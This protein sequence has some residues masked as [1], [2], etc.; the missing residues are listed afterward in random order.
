MR[1][2][3][4]PSYS[5]FQMV[6]APSA[7]LSGPAGDILLSLSEAPW[8][9]LSSEY[10]NPLA[11]IYGKPLKQWQIGFDEH[12]RCVLLFLD[13]TA[14]EGVG[15]WTLALDGK[16]LTQCPDV[17]P[18]MAA[19]AALIETLSAVF[20]ARNAPALTP[21]MFLEE[22]IVRKRWP[23]VLS[24]LMLRGE[25]MG[26]LKNTLFSMLETIEPVGFTPQHAQASAR[27]LQVR[28]LMVFH[29]LIDDGVIR[30]AAE[31]KRLC[32]IIRQIESQNESK[33]MAPVAGPWWLRLLKT[34][35]EE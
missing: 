15:E 10:D 31:Q 11:D 32:K 20:F 25:V 21:L 2:Y 30:N 29:K 34:C 27:A 4:F 18:H 8:A 5:P 16:I 22:A 7:G 19:D 1:D 35:G 28:L 14:Y 9:R 24:T 23:K 33:N 3:R 12:G 17:P 6:D 13:K 26:T